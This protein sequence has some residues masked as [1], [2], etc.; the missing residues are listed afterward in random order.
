MNATVQTEIDGIPVPWQLQPDCGI[1]DMSLFN[2]WRSGIG[3]NC[4]SIPD[5]DLDLYGDL[6][7][8][9]VSDEL[10]AL[11]FHLGGKWVHLT[12]RV[13]HERVLA[14]QTAFAR[15][16]I[17]VQQSIV[18]AT[19]DPLDRLVG[20]L[21][22]MR[23]G[24]I[25]TPL[26]PGGPTR[27]K[28]ELEWVNPDWLDADRDLLQWLPEHWK[29]RCLLPSNGPTLRPTESVKLTP[30]AIAIRWIDPYHPG[31]EGILDMPAG[32]LFN[33]LMRDSSL[34]LGLRRGE[35][36]ATIRSCHRL[37]PFLELVVLFA[38]ANFISLDAEATDE[39][40]RTLLEDPLTVV[41]LPL[42]IAEALTAR[43]PDAA[44][45]WGRWYRDALEVQMINRWAAV[46][47]GLKLKG[48][49]SAVLHWSLQS[50]TVVLGTPWNNTP[51]DLDVFPASGVPW[52]LGDLMAPESEAKLGFGRYCQLTGPKDDPL[53]QATPL[54]IS[55]M[56][57]QALRVVG[58][59]P[60][61]C[62]RGVY[63]TAQALQALS[64]EGTWQFVVE[65]EA[66]A[67]S[68]RPVRNILLCFMDPRSS[69]A[70]QT[71]LER[72]VGLNAV[73]DAICHL[74][75]MPRFT[76]EGDLDAPWIQRQYLNGELLRREAHPLYQALSRFKLELINVLNNPT[77]T[78][79]L[80][81]K[82]DS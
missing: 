29:S 4:Q 68:D 63:P 10:T 33:S 78:S 38:G 69:E 46:V 71:V 80:V 73:P 54:M 39:L 59:F 40:R 34:V 51:T 56:S 23:A 32:I 44:P 7:G 35:T 2:W 26:I 43:P 16:P 25:P 81:Q 55:R 12:Y 65:E 47:D 52:Q 5:R 31:P 42:E 9:H 22:A 37:A 3:F 67:D 13:L 20:M 24:L 17:E 48:L 72:E 6:V 28:M 11:S 21:A 41:S 8:R 1:D 27:L 58:T 64:M 76:E 30:E 66:A 79:S 60:R 70:L 61:G 19:R 57:G 18:I 74:N 36:L 50:G 49:P 45:Q 15:Y 75:M 53:I 14:Q 62:S 82:G 77:S